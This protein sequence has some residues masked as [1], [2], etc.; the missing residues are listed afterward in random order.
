M[1]RIFSGRPAE[2]GTTPWIAMLSHPNDVPFCGGTLLGLNW[3]VTAAHCLHQPV[4]SEDSRLH[5]SHLLHPSDFKIILGKHWRR[6]SD[7]DEQHLHVKQIILHP[8]YNPSTFENDV[9]LLELLE[10]PTLNNFVMPICLPEEPSQEG[11]VVLVSGWGKQ[12][13]Q[14]FSEAL[15]ELFLHL[16]HRAVSE[17][18][19]KVEPGQLQDSEVQGS[20]ARLETDDCVVFQIEIPLVD[21]RTCKEAYAPLKRKVTEDM[22]C[23]G[24][25]EGGKDACAGDSGGPMVTLDRKRGQWYLVGTV[26]WGEGCGQKDRYGVYS[27]I[28]HNKRWI[29]DVTGVKN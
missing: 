29:Q 6:R 15:M 28:Y 4:D 22:I 10:S 25:K 13:L 20:S 7:A 16:Y 17:P 9:A 19:S 21:H 5:T 27:Y 12:F 8:L 1:A 24:E 2:K 14:R 18:T 3:L 11:A 26:S 23:A